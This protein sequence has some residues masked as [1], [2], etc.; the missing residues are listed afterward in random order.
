VRLSRALREEEERLAEQ[1]A[2]ELERSHPRLASS[3]E[4]VLSV[5]GFL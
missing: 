5:Y 4:E 1:E 2:V 3:G